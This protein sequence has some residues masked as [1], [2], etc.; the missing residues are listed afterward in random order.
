MWHILGRG[1][2]FLGYWWGNMWDKDYLRGLVIDGIII[3]NWIYKK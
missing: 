2:V 3:L 1:D